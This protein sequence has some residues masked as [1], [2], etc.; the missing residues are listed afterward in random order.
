SHRPARRVVGGRH[1]RAPRAHRHAARRHRRG[2]QVRE[3]RGRGRGRRGRGRGDDRLRGRGV[4]GGRGGRRGRR[5]R[6]G[7]GRGGGGE[8]VPSPGSLRLR[9]PSLPRDVR[10]AL[11]GRVALVGARELALPGGAG[12]VPTVGE[13]VD[14]RGQAAAR[15]RRVAVVAPELRLEPEDVV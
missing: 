2:R 15:R 4:R 12:H 10:A 9:R 3:A 14:E 8:V 1:G 13:V 6:R 7:R 5:G 11:L